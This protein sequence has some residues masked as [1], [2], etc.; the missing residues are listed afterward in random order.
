MKLSE[1]VI[2]AHLS[3]ADSLDY[4][5][6]EGLLTVVGREIIPTEFV[7]RLTAWALEQ[8]FASGRMVAPSTEAI[9]STWA[10]QL[11]QHEI[12]LDGDT[13]SDSVQWA[14]ADLRANY[15]RLRAEEIINDFA[16]DMSAADGPDRVEVF[17]KYA[18]T[19]FLTSQSLLSH[20]NEMLGYQGVDDALRRLDDR[21]ATGR[22]TRGL[23]LGIDP[24]DAHSFG[25][26]PGEITTIGGSPGVGKSWLAGFIALANWKAGR[27]VLLVTLE[28]DVPM[29]YDRL[30]CMARMIN[31][32]K[33]Q[34]GDLTTGQR[35]SVLSLRE[36]ML[37]SDRQPIFA[38]LDPSQRTAS[39]IIRKAMLDD[40]DGVIIDQLNFLHAEDVHK[41]AKRFE[42]VG[43]I[44]H[45]MKYLANEGVHQLPVILLSQMKREGISA[46]RKNGKYHLDDFADSSAIEQTSDAAW[47]IYQTADMAFQCEA[48]LQQLKS[49]RTVVRD[50]DLTWRPE[51][52]I[53]QA[54][55]DPV[56]Q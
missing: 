13:E 46:A 33:W 40:A 30:C 23:T 27:R 49:R 34:R 38:Q 43:E 28:N 25:T 9:R 53:I 8:F 1:S 5:A 50:F 36:E 45:R 41:S 2:L 16:R 32:D 26:H 56:S 39:G 29:T 37:A 19:M 48:R 51:I 18:D 3:N 55:P 10:D 4:L 14:V 7:Q 52:G 15:A 44:M 42:A 12:V 54:K 17:A 31:Y 21:I 47:A 11:E 24:I 20:R 22:I 6:R 35:D